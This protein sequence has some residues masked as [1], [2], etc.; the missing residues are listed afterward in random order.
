M[1]AESSKERKV[2][3]YDTPEDVKRRRTSRKDLIDSKERK[4]IADLANDYID[5]GV[6]RHKAFTKARQIIK[7]QKMVPPKTGKK[8]TETSHLKQDWRPVIGG[9]Y[10]NAPMAR[11]AYT[12][13]DEKYAQFKARVRTEASEMKPFDE[14]KRADAVEELGMSFHWD[15]TQHW[16]RWRQILDRLGFYRENGEWDELSVHN[17]IVQLDAYDPNIPDD[18]NQDNIHMV[19]DESNKKREQ[20]LHEFL[21]SPEYSS[22]LESRYELFLEKELMPQVHFGME[23]EEYKH[24]RSDSTAGQLPS[25]SGRPTK[26]RRSLFAAAVDDDDENVQEN[27]S[28]S[29]QRDPFEALPMR[30]TSSLMSLFDDVDE[31]DPTSWISAR[32]SCTP[33]GVPRPPSPP[34]LYPPSPPC[35][36]RKVEC[37]NCGETI[38]YGCEDKYSKFITACSSKCAD[39]YFYRSNRE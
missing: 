16:D 31:D 32:F 15:D 34:T 37:A 4:Q 19:I 10:R 11:E 24:A 17:A 18:V 1:S 13:S 20:E 6:P 26:I 25:R 2:G 27:Q 36:P 35:E 38:T 8:E 12:N 14:W 5:R 29:S 22:R 33:T 3:F 30:R 23:Y 7:R 21:Q 9:I 28:S 39:E